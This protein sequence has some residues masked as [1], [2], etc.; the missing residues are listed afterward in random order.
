MTKFKGKASHMESNLITMTR[1]LYLALQT[2][3]KHTA[4]R[5][6]ADP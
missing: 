6:Q 1:K 5:K 4:V 2:N 3:R